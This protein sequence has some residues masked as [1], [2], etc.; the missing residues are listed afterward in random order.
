ML[1]VAGVVV[2]VVAVVVVVVV[3]VGDRLLLLFFSIPG[4][5]WVSGWFCC[6]ITEPHYKHKQ[7]RFKQ[8]VHRL[9]WVSGRWVPNPF[10]PENKQCSNKN[11]QTSFQ[12][13]LVGGWVR[14]AL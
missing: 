6:L 2:A 7:T 4:E 8:N 14:Q 10:E 13:R 5:R 3:V 9:G 12:Y 1:V 11:K